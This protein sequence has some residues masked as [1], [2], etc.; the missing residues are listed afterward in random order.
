[1]E[2]YAV[3]LSFVKQKEFDKA[4]SALKVHIQH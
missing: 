3:I 4:S 2:G 1:M